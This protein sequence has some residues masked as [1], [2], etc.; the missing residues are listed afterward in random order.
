MI[1]GI[2]G[3]ESAKFTALGEKRARRLIRKLIVESGA[4]AIVSGACHLG[5]IDA[6]A[7]EEAR[8]AGVKVKEYPPRVR[9]WEGYRERNVKIATRADRVVCITVKK[10]PKGYRWKGFEDFCYHCQTSRH[11]KSGGCWTAKYARSIGKPGTTLV[12]QNE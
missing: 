8:S 6:W 1:L 5:G 11:I 9:R 10:L 12:I 4:R 2:V 7:I 3:S